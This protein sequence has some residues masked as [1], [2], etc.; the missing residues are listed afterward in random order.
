MSIFDYILGIM[1]VIWILII[2]I[3]RKLNYPLGTYNG[4]VLC[5]IPPFIKRIRL[6]GKWIGFNKEWK[7]VF[8]KKLD[9]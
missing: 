6:Q 5:L 1:F 9:R 4:I 2:Y 8:F 7:F 3:E